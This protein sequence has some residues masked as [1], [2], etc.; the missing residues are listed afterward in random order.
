MSSRIKAV[1]TRKGRVLRIDKQIAD[2][3][4]KLKHLNN[5]KARLESE[6]R[7]FMN[8]E[9][10][11]LV[12]DGRHN[13]KIDLSDVPVINDFDQ[14]FKFVKK[15]NCPE[16]LHQRVNTMAWRE[17]D[18]N[19]PGVGTFTRETIKITRRR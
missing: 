15:K 5:E 13:V 9:G 10:V 7:E 6:M 12:S 11:D 14:F 4:K 17:R 19:V 1:L 8:K 16:L 18:Q 3:K 2:C